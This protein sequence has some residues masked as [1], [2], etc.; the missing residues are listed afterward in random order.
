MSKYNLE[1]KISLKNEQG[2]ETRYVK[3]AIDES[4]MAS[5]MTTL[6][7]SPGIDFVTLR[8]VQEVKPKVGDRVKIAGGKVTEVVK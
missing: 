1:Y 7:T 2:I 6:A 5:E 3:R 8:R 4:A